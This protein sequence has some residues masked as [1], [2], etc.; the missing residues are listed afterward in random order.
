MIAVAWE[1]ASTEILRWAYALGFTSWSGVLAF[2]LEASLV[3]L[4]IALGRFARR[5]RWTR[6]P[7]E[8]EP[9]RRAS[10]ELRPVA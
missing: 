3:A 2:A 1:S 7:S 8:P 10:P 4:A 9:E 6:P 5:S